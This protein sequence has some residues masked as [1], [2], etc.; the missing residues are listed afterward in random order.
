MA[1]YLQIWLASTN[2]SLFL[3]SVDL[4]TTILDKNVSDS[5]SIGTHGVGSDVTRYGYGD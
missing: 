1:K 4:S 2:I 5:F 3:A